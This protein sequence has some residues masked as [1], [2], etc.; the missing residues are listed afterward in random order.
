[1]VGVSNHPNWITFSRNSSNPQNSQRVIT[2]INIRL[3]NLCF[4]LHKDLLDYRDISFFNCSSIY[5][6]LNV[7][8]DSS[9]IT[10]KYFKDTEANINNVLIMSGDFNI[11]DS[12]WDP[13]FPNYS[14]HSDILTDIADSLNLYISSTTVQVL[15]R[16]VDNLNVDN[17]ND[18]NSVIN[19]IFLWLNLDEFDNYTIYSNWKL[20]SDHTPLTVKASIFD[21]NIQIKKWTIIKNSEE[22]VN[23]IAEV[24]ELIKRLNTN[25][26]NS[27]KD[28]EHIIQDFTNSTDVSWCKYSRL[29]NITKHSKVWWNENCQRYLEIYR[30][31]RYLK[32]WKNFKKAVKNT[33]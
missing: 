27:K 7:Y 13:L 21:E 28:F 6:M 32:D 11:R 25:H 20:S 30:E 9:Q 17:L 1:M 26:I 14:V 5:F 15:T 24:I 16:Y 19:L 31:L 2:Y 10:L 33:K 3:L 18:L 12:F 22:E 8:S 23:F 29:A 4:S